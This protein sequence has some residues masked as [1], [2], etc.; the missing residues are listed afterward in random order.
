MKRTWFR[1]C[2]GFI[3]I[4]MIAIPVDA[5]LNNLQI[6]GICFLWT[7]IMAPLKNED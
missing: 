5:H 4:M 7:A 1:F 2:I 3:G 6:F